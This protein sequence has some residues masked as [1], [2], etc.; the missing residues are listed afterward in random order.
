MLYKYRDGYKR[1]FTIVKNMIWA[2]NFKDRMISV[3]QLLLMI[4]L[5]SGSYLSEILCH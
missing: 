3:K 2:I 4:G 1:S 5:L